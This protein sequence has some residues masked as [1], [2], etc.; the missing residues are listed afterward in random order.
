MVFGAAI[1]ALA[2]GSAADNAA[3]A[4][5]EALQRDLYYKNLGLDEQQRQFDLQQSLIAPFVQS[6]QQAIPALQRG[7]SSLNI[8][9]LLNY[10]PYSQL[11]MEKME[12]TGNY[13]GSIGGLRS[14]FGQKQRASAGTDALSN[15][16]NL[17]NQLQQ[18]L[19]GQAQTGSFTLGSQGAQ[20]ASNISN[21]LQA[22]GQA[23]SANALRQG[24]IQTQLGSNLAALGAATADYYR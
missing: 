13:L 18:S 19:A 11:A 17:L 7:A 4:S 14:G 3:T 21:L 20:T 22:Q 10:A 6:G 16:E 23:A 15:I 5:V 8:S 9:Q 1:G 12:D 2:Q 24:N